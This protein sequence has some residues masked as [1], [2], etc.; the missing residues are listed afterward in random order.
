MR[1]SIVIPALDEEGAIGTTVRA[2][3][4]A[5]PAIAAEAG[6]DDIEVLVVDDGS[7]DRTAEIVRGIAG[8]RLVQHPHNRGYG[9][10]ISTGFRHATGELLAFLDA[11]GTCDARQFGALTRTLLARDADVVSGSRLGAGNQMPAVRRLG[12]RIFATLI[13]LVSPQHIE[14]LASGMRVIRKRAMPRLMPLP[15]GLHYTPAMSAKC[16]FDPQLALVEVPIPYAERVGESKLSVIRDGQRFLRVLAE[17]ALSYRPFFFFG[18]AGLLLLLVALA[19]FV[20]PAVELLRHQ[21][22]PADM[23][24]RIYTIVVLASCGVALIGLGLVAADATAIL[25][26]RVRRKHWLHRLCELLLLRRPFLVGT[27]LFAFAIVLNRHSLHTYLTQRRIDEHWI[28]VVIGGLLVLIGV[29]LC[30]LGVMRKILHMLQERR[31]ARDADPG[32]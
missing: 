17:I 15:D 10:A 12:N 24:Y 26:E 3:L 13:N 6:I 4:D 30:A 7:T 14:D 29:Q 20:T 1:L 18:G 5:G 31:Q 27:A 25:H 32:S 22:L 23:I 9:A 28:V 2:C 21:V 8:A 11:D 16:L 19:Y